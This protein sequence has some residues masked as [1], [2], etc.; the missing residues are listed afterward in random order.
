M[1]GLPFRLSLWGVLRAPRLPGLFKS[2]TRLGYTISAPD[3]PSA[4]QAATYIPVPLPDPKG[5]DHN[6]RYSQATRLREVHGLPPA[7]LTG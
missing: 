1:G 7:Y 5:D 6:L 3:T 2:T 4:R